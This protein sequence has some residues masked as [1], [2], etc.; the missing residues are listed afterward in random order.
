M[1][2]ASLVG[3]GHAV[4]KGLHLGFEVRDDYLRFRLLNAQHTVLMGSELFT[5]YLPFT[6]TWNRSPEAI[7]SAI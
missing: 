4:H 5:R 1:C 7:K 6:N 3:C 2:I